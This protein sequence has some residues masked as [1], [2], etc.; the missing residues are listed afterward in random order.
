MKFPARTRDTKAPTSF[1]SSEEQVVAKRELARIVR[2]GTLNLVGAVVSAATGFLQVVVVTRFFTPEDAG[3]LFSATSAFTILVTVAMLGT[4]T[5]LARFWLPLKVHG[6]TTD[7]EVMRRVA[8]RPV[9]FVSFLAVAVGFLA[10]GWIS[11]RIGIEG[12][13]A[14]TVVRLMVIFVPIATLGRFLLAET[15]ALGR[16]RPTVVIDKLIRSIAQPLG[17]FVVGL[18]G[19]GLIA[20]S[21]SWVAPFGLAL[22]LATPLVRRSNGT[23]LS[24]RAKS[25]VRRL[26]REFWSFTWPRSLASI[27]QIAIQ[28]FD[29]IV[30]ASAL[31]AKEAAIYTA[32]TRFVVVGQFAV[33]AIQQILQ[34]RMSAM[35]AKDQLTALKTVF[36]TATAWNVAVAWPLYITVACGASI[37]LGVFGQGYTSSTAVGVVV[38]MAVAMMLAVAAGPL[39]TLLLMAGHSRASTVNALVALFVNVI[40]CIALIPSFGIP[41]AAV[42]WGAAVVVRNVLTYFQVRSALNISPF[43]PGVL[44]AVIL[45]LVAFALPQSVAVTVTDQSLTSFGVATAAGFLLYASGLWFARNLLS[46]SSLKAL[47]P[48]R[49]T[50]K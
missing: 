6:R 41:G 3:S 23:A 42:A 33:A 25:D 32:A 8:L 19:G 49:L 2:G 48:R 15:Q 12:P 7:L 13:A 44:V 38:T 17:A 1:E 35:L 26:R 22:L 18:T 27:S 4:E 40:L 29:I 11:H 46:L 37:Y 5:G 21:G 10:A 34:P 20:L 30:I 50:E 43:S 28:R 24:P 9:L 36:Q 14:S 39:D 16:M 31:G 47:L 45:P